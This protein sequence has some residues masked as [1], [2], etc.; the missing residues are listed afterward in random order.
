MNN[1]E[2]IELMSPAGKVVVDKKDVEDYLKREGWSLVQKPVKDE[3][4]EI[5]AEPEIFEEPD[6]PDELDVSGEVEEIDQ[7]STEDEEKD[8]QIE[9]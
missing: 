3:T 7:S 9:D 8:D 4:P 5:P 6:V 2:T 1:L